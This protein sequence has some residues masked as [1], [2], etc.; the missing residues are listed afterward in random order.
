MQSDRELRRKS[1]RP[2]KYNAVTVKRICA[3]I[4]KGM[5]FVRAAA[6]GGISQDT[7]CTWRNIHP[8]FS[9]AIEQ[10]VSKGMET[11][12]G[13]IQNA[14]KKGDVGSAKWLLEHVHPE[15]FAR[16]RMEVKHEVEGHLKHAIIVSPE[17]LE[18]IAKSRAR[19]EEGGMK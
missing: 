2:T 6:S 15:H 7:F 4:A 3:A 10:A 19:Y 1:G 5:P 11:N 9:E 13:I 17:V 16:N 12:L 8:E 14:A 18:Q